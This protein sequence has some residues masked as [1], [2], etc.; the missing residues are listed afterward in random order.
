MSAQTG[1]IK[2]E[3]KGKKRKDRY[4]SVAYGN[5]F[6]SMLEQDLLSDSS[7]YEY[8]TIID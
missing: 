5:Y 3:E 2:V 6:A 7:E 1:Y 8:L 4:T